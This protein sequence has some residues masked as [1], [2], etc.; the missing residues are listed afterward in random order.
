MSVL[1]IARN[2]AMPGRLQGTSLE[3]AAG[4]LVGL[5]GPNGSGKTS[6]LQALAGIPP[7]TGEV[8]IAGERPKS[9]AP[10][11]RQRLFTFLP[12]SRDV[13]WPLTARDFINLA[14][15]DETYW[16]ALADR[17]ELADVIDRRMD[18]LSTGERT[19]VM[20]A[21]ALAPDPAVLLLDEPIANLDPYWQV[22]ILEELRCRARENGRTAIVAIHDLRAALGWS[23]RLLLMDGGQV[24][25]DANPSA[26]RATGLL[27]AT[28]RVDSDWSAARPADRQSLP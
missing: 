11:A 22:V 1:L 5:I 15:P 23:D 3:T 12:A 20:I 28:F 21:R 4:Q 2:L 7:A 16:S 17:L 27:E 13:A 14:L 10:N 9:L 26:L 18:R 19:R 6:L 24:I 25:A 8:T